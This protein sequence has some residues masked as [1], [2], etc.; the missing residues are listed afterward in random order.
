MKIFHALTTVF[1]VDEERL[2]DIHINISTTADSLSTY[3]D[4]SRHNA[5]LRL[6][7]FHNFSMHSIFGRN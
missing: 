6:Q 7:L 5:V 2:S 4:T 3:S 1:Q